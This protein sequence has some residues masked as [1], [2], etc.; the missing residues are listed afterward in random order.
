MLDPNKDFR[1]TAE[2]KEGFDWAALHSPELVERYSSNNLSAQELRGYLWKN[3]DRA[4]PSKRGEMENELRQTLFVA[5]AIREIIG[6]LPTNLE[7]IR[8][9]YEIAGEMGQIYSAEKWK[10][11]HFLELKKKDSSWWRK[12]KGDASPNEVVSALANYWWNKIARERGV[13]STS[14][15]E[16]LIDTLGTREMCA[17]ASL[18]KVVL[19]DEG[20][21]KTYD[22]EGDDCEFQM[23]AAPV[24]ENGRVY[25]LAGEIVG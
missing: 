10:Y 12:K 18:G 9:L 1:E 13:K 4:Y 2:Y 22:V 7:S 23:M 6:H 17:L 19:N 3:A 21:Y 20:K 24:I 14:K 11:V 8:A 16:I 25:S 15:W 5:G